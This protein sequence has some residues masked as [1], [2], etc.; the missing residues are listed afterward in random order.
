[1]LYQKGYDDG[2]FKL[3]IVIFYLHYG[4]QLIIVF[5]ASKCSPSGQ[6]CA[7]QTFLIIPVHV[8]TGPLHR[9]DPPSPSEG[10]V[11]Q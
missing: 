10:E 11:R 9:C 5:S 1:M 8:K 7:A 4:Q 6:I 3:V 2:S